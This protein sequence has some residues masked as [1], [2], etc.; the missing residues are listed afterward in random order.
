MCVPVSFFFFLT[1]Q[2]ED[3]ELSFMMGKNVGEEQV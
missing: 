2:L 3:W 1:K